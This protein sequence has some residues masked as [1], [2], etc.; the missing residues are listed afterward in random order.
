MTGYLFSA[1]VILILSFSLLW[2]IVLCKEVSVFSKKYSRALWNYSLIGIFVGLL[3]GLG[4]GAF[5]KPFVNSLME[6][7]TKTWGTYIPLIER[8]GSSFLSCLLLKFI[9]LTILYSPSLISVVTIEKVK[10]NSSALSYLKEDKI[11]SGVFDFLEKQLSSI[12][13]FF[14]GIGF[15]VGVTCCLF[16]KEMLKTFVTLTAFSAIIFAGILIT[17][18]MSYFE[19]VFFKEDK[20]VEKR[21]N[22][23]ETKVKNPWLT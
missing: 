2:L 12:F 5:G 20:K 4:I 21:E 6:C 17:Y 14:F 3:V 13:V 18:L 1:A 7:G 23:G 15:A 11:P 22:A 16:P 19:D 10:I 8:V 9:F